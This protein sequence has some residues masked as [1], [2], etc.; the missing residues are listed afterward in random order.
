MNSEKFRVAPV[1]PNANTLINPVKSFGLIP[2]K[3]SELWQHRENA[4]AGEG[5]TSLSLR[6][7]RGEQLTQRVS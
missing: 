3:R 7:W 2:S 4:T 1:Q 6:E 5:K